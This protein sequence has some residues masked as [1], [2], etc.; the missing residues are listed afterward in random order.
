L[1]Y[2]FDQSPRGRESRWRDHITNIIVIKQKIIS[3]KKLSL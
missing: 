1:V 2:P 3:D